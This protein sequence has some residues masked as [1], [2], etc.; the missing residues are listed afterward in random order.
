MFHVKH[1]VNKWA[2]LNAERKLRNELK[3]FNTAR[4]SI[5]YAGLQ[6]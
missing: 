3:R 4:E 5:S 2:H 6:Q 1:K